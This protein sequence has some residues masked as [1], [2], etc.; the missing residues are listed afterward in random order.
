MRGIAATAPLHKLMLPVS[1]AFPET[2]ETPNGA[3]RMLDVLNDE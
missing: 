1:Q 2:E 3:E